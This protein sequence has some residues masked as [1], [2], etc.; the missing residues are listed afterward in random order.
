MLDD[1]VVEELANGVTT[2]AVTWLRKNV[3]GCGYLTDSPA[4]SSTAAA[5]AVA[6]LDG[7]LAC[8]PRGVGKAGRVTSAHRLSSR[9]FYVP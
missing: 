2:L 7:S 4:V 5:A 9:R 6:D 3:G 8:H 1:A